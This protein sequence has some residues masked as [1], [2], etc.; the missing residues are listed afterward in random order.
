MSCVDPD[1]TY[2]TTLNGQFVKIDAKCGPI[3]E[4]VS[5]DAPLQLGLKTGE[6]CDVPLENSPGNT[7]AA[8]SSFYQI[9]RAIEWGQYYLPGN[10]WLTGQLEVN[11]NIADT[12]NASWNG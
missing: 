10:T 6:N 1:A 8:R 9:N 12:C 2:Q 3:S 4:T 5:C 11:T 7:A